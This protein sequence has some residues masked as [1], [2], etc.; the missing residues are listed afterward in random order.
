[1]V[2]AVHAGVSVAE[3]GARRAPSWPLAFA[4]AHPWR[5]RRRRSSN[6]PIRCFA[7]Q[8]RVDYSGIGATSKTAATAAEIEGVA[9]TGPLAPGLAADHPILSRAAKVRAIVV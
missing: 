7:R 9:T 1:M 8:A 3:A 2:V 4:S 6:E 5:W